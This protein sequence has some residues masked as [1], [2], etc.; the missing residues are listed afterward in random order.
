MN[1][2][3]FVG[4]V[5][6]LATGILVPAV[7]SRPLHISTTYPWEGKVFVDCSDQDLGSDRLLGVDRV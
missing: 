5:A 3:D 4:T 6:R 7:E 2:R 1:R